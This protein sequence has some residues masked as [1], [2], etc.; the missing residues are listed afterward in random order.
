[1][2]A[3]QSTELDNVVD[4]AH[5]L[6]RQRDE[7]SARR[8]QF[9]DQRKEAV[10]RADTI[11]SGD[12][13]LQIEMSDAQ[14]AASAAREALSVL[15]SE[16]ADLRVG[17]AALGQ[18]IEEIERDRQRESRDRDQAL[19]AAEQRDQ[20]IEQ[21]TKERTAV[22]REIAQQIE[23][24]KALSESREEASRKAIE[25]QNQ[26][27]TLLDETE[28][29][30]KELKEQRDV[31]R[32]A[33]ANLHRIEMG[34]RHDEDRVGFFQE[35]IASE[36]AVSLAGLNAD[37]VGTDEYDEA[38]RTQLVTDIR[39]KLQRM[40]DVNLTAI[41]EYEELEKRHAF[42]QTQMRDL[43]QAREALLGVI[44]R[45]DKRIREMFMDTF[46]RIGENFG[47]FFR[48][49]FNGGQARVYLI[50]EDD[51]L[52]SGIEIE[53]RPPGKKP[54]SISLLSGGESAMTAVALLFSIFK[55]KPSPFCVLDE[56]DAPLDDANIGRFLGLLEEFV[57][58]SQFVVITHNKQTMAKAD[59]LYGVTQ[60]ERGVSQLV[61]VKFD[62][63]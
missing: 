37:Q 1:D 63:K 51:P 55:A 5:G 30:D 45:S 32:D 23:R 21:L 48:R 9:E 2:I 58:Q 56:V 36:Y 50:D 6:D 34:L 60:Q 33:Q 3:R 57:D 53:A 39:G 14:E 24:S 44:E 7:L 27:Q 29:L 4:A 10:Q 19:A 52:E 59:A 43:N 22:E 42:L 46:N 28:A 18:R 62:G 12:E 11:Q 17:Q 25:A 13:A 26:L 8:N 20:L 16:L 47:H 61:G 40:G 49:L 31:A 35:R 54:T 38:T 15:A 41:E